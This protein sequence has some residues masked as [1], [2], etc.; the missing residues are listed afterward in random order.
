M[1]FGFCAT[2]ELLIW[3]T[4][5]LPRPGVGGAIVGLVVLSGNG[6]SSAPDPASVPPEAC[7]SGLVSAFLTSAP[8]VST[9]A[10]ILLLIDFAS[11]G[12][13]LPRL[14]ASPIRPGTAF[15]LYQR[16]LQCPLRFRL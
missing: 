9:V 8:I 5:Q 3:P 2:F 10:A 4:G 1:T 12:A 14:P 11:L 15:A 7:L 6:Y 13:S 16:V